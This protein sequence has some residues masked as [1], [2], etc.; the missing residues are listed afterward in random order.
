MFELERKLWFK[1]LDFV[2]IFSENVGI[3]SCL[4]YRFLVFNFLRFL[5]FLCLW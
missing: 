2:E 3:G 1:I 4:F 5:M